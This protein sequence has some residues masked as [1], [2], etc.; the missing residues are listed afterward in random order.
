MITFLLSFVALI[1]GYMV[2][3]KFVEKV[4]G[5]NENLETP[6]YTKTDGV[7][8]VPMD[9][10]RGSLVQ[11]LNI[12]GLG[13][14]FGPI[15]GALWGPVAFLWIVLGGIFAGAV[16]DYFSGMLS[17]RNGG[18]QLPDIVGKYL[19]QGM[20]HFVNVFSV[21]LLIL[22]GTVFVAGPA[23]LIVTLTPSWIS[24]GVVTTGIFIYY[25]LATLL[26]ID[27]IIGKIYPVFGLLLIIMAVGVGVGLVVKGY[28][29]PEL[30]LSNLHPKNLPMWPLLFI[31]IACGAVSGFHATQSPLIA[32]TVQNEKYGRKVFYGM[33]IAES[34]IALIWA[35]AGMAV[36]GGT[37]GLQEALAVGGPAGVVRTVSITM[38]GAIGGTLA[39]IGVIILPITSGDTAFRGARM[40]IADFFK[41]DQKP[42]SKRLAISIPLFAVAFGLSLIDF[43][44]LWRYFSWANQTTAMILLWAAAMYLVKEN[45][46]HWIATIPAIFMT[47]VSFTYLLQ[48]P[49]GFGLPT[50]ISYPAGLLITV[51]ITVL[52]ASKVRKGRKLET[53]KIVPASSA[54]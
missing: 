16:H 22:V 49:E 9:S 46:L 51:G 8:Y 29:I 32:R 28:P 4:F 18:A 50:S 1:I 7:D 54:K 27:K 36:F 2:Y 40:V 52:F 34:A 14:I 30:T 48:A 13:P 33:M 21:V 43:N 10:N 19:G 47:A 24:L 35:A 41:M 23:N 12:A 53:E 15:A 17:V 11:L 3:G 37:G 26:P 25:I 31:T 42:M 6:A 44:F 5:I 45:R 39:I 20:R 38:L